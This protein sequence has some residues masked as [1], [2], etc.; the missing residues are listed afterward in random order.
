MD[1]AWE[2]LAFSK[3]CKSIVEVCH[4]VFSLVFVCVERFQ[5]LHCNMR[6]CLKLTFNCTVGSYLAMPYAVVLSSTLLKSLWIIPGLVLVPMEKSRFYEKVHGEVTRWMRKN[7]M[8]DREQLTR[9][10]TTFLFCTRTALL[11]IFFS[12]NNYLSHQHLLNIRN[13]LVYSPI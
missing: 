10:L 8:I 2:N 11:S 12:N 9:E 3:N 1:S 5:V 4:V 7:R 6:S 13:P